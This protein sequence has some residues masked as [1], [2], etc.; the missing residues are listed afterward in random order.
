MRIGIDIDGVLTDIGQW[1][2]DYGTKYNFDI[3]KHQ[4]ININSY[5]PMKIFNWNTVEEKGFWLQYNDLYCQKEPIRPFAASII[6]KLKQEN[7]EI[8]IITARLECFEGKD[9]IKNKKF[10]L[11]WLKKNKV[12]YDKIIFSS[13][14]KLEICIK[15]DIAL[16]IEDSPY[17]INN[18]SKKIPVICYDTFYNKECDNK[19]IT[20]CYSWYD[21]YDKIKND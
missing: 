5:E 20:R 9:K 3:N 17:N 21:I 19:N 7:N 4:K 13:N 14:E 11:K 6:N 18:I 1:Q 8:Y 15:N 2:L 16:M 12:K 10:I